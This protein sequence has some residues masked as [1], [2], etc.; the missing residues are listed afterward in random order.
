MLL[1][2]DKNMKWPK[3]SL[4]SQ[5]SRLSLAFIQT[6]GS[7]EVS[8]EFRCLQ[9]CLDWNVMCNNFMYDPLKSIVQ[10]TF[11]KHQ[12]RYFIGFGSQDLLRWSTESVIKTTPPLPSSLLGPLVCEWQ[13]Q[14]QAHRHHW[15]LWWNTRLEHA[16]EQHWL[17][18]SVCV[19]LWLSSQLGEAIESNVDLVFPALCIQKRWNSHCI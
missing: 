16:K 10:F 7:D 3:N 19:W 8:A 18:C 6:V 9:T 14:M 17:T 1:P 11:F 15:A 5:F 2:N 4:L 12:R 13:H